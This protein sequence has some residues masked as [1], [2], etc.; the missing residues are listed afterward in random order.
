MVSTDHG[1]YL[2]DFE[3]IPSIGFDCTVSNVFIITER[4]LDEIGR[5]IVSLKSAM[6][7]SSPTLYTKK[8]LFV[9]VK[10]I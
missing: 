6:L 9:M 10:E 7:S 4:L 5:S 3:L 1:G 2:L 8:L